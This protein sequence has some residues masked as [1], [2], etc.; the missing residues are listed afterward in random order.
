MQEWNEQ[1]L[2]KVLPPWLK[3]RKVAWWKHQ[4]RGQ[5]KG[6]VG[7]RKKEERRI[8]K[9]M[10]QAVTKGMKEKAKVCED[11]K[12]IVQRSGSQSVWQSWEWDNSQIGNSSN[13][14]CV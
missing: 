8:R 4:G 10:V 1:K 13:N 3:W 14:A 5:D 7:T 6:D 9:K 12:S 11:A 2:P